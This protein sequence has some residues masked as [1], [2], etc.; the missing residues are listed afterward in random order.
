M[1]INRPQPLEKLLNDSQ[2]RQI[3][4]HSQVLQTLQRQFQICCDKHGLRQCR[5]ANFRNG[6]LVI[7]V[8]SAAW[9]QRLNLLRATVLSEL[10]Q[11]LPQLVS[12]E[13]VQNP[14]MANVPASRPSPEVKRTISPQAAAHLEELA[15]TAPPG[16]K[17]KLRKLA[18][19][20]GEK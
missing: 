14:A 12:L 8:G 16:L 5:V 6:I 17:E 4:R 10:R 19:L 18:A 11:S 2:F 13:V 9:R 3:C 15:A 1:P 7:E 20:A